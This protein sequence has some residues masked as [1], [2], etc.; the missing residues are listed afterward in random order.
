MVQINIYS[1]YGS[2]GGVVFYS[3][4]YPPFVLSPCDPVLVNLD[5]DLYSGYYEGNAK[6]RIRDRDYCGNNRPLLE[7][8][9]IVATGFL[10]DGKLQNQF[11]SKFSRYVL[12]EWWKI[13]RGKS[14]KLDAFPNKYQFPHIRIIK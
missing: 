7:D 8:E 6:Y 1:A 4:R 11:Q 5:I 12:E 3:D 2:L 10:I 14:P 9:Y 13:C